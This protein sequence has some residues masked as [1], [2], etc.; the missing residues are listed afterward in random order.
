MMLSFAEVSDIVED[1]HCLPFELCVTRSTSPVTLLVPEKAGWPGYVE[2]RFAEL[3]FIQAW[4]H[5]KDTDT[6]EEGWGHGSMYFID[7]TSEPDDVV[8]RCFV[9]MRDYAEHEVREAF[10]WKQT[11]VLSP[12]VPLQELL[13]LL[14]TVSA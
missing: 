7:P 6:H 2:E 5:R 8:K 13:R 4:L 12:H 14:Q 1:I 3:V 10:H 9:A 11:R